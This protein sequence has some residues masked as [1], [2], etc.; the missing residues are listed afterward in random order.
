MDM[1][2]F[3]ALLGVRHPFWL[4]AA[5]LEAEKTKLLDRPD[6]DFDETLKEHLATESAK[7]WER[8]RPGRSSLSGR[9][10]WRRP[11]TRDC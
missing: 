8:E 11:T 3:T 7:K 5:Q 9:E 2:N 10:S 1:R 6:E 4:F